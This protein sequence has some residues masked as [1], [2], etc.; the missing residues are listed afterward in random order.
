MLNRLGLRP[1]KVEQEAYL[2]IWRHVGFYIG[3][4][5]DILT[6]YFSCVQTADKFLG[7]LIIHVFSESEKETSQTDPNHCSISPTVPILEAVS[8]R[9]PLYTSFTYNCAAARYFMGDALASHLLNPQAGRIVRI[10][11]LFMQFLQAYA[12][13]FGNTYGTF[14]RPSWRAKRRAV[15]RAGLT[16]TVRHSLGMRKTSFRPVDKETPDMGVNEAEK[17]IPD[18]LGAKVLAQ[19]WREVIIEMVV[20]T[21]ATTILVSWMGWRVIGT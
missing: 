11:L 19:R 6:R 15:L 20:V 3:V 8:N 4:S 17:V 18:F 7:S 14:I 21:V 1:T 12:V 5:P 13:F 16:R 9:A 2:A 10:K